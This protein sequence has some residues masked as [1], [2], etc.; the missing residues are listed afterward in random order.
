MNII[1]AGAGRVGYNLAKTLSPYQNVVVIDKNELALNSMQESLDILPLNG[2]VEDPSTYQKLLDREFDLFIAVTDKDEANLI[3]VII[4]SDIIDIERTIIRLEN[5]FFAKSSLMQKF[6]IDEAIFPIE[7]TTNTILNLIYYSKA[8]NV[9][10]FKYT[11][12]KLIS[13][14]LTNLDGAVEIVPQGFII[15]GIERGK[16]FIIPQSNQTLYPNDLIYLFGDDISIIKFCQTY[17]ED[18]NRNENIVIFGAGE[19]GISIA[20]ALLK[21]GKNVKIVDKD[22]KKCKKANSKLSG[23]AIVLNCKYSTSEL[24]EEEGLKYADIVIAATNNDEY[25]IIKCL[26]AKEKGVKKIVAINH[27]LE[28]YQLM[29]SLDI[30]VVRGPKVSAYNTILER[31]HSSSIVAE[32][33]FCGGKGHIY[34]HRI[35]KNSKVVNKEIKIPK[36]KN[37]MAIYLIRDNRILECK[38]S[39]ECKVDD[40]IVA[41]CTIEEDD[42]VERWIH[43]L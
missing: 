24:Y 35:L 9:K 17:G 42:E 23:E 8:N 27:D 14:R 6:G 33:N 26:E 12:K 13:I 43:N 4:A 29:H 7:L 38:N 32:R 5:H 36:W 1:I 22:L 41:F 34:L 3:S 10:S 21:E 40:V 25:N 16:E 37:N 18:I 28:H 11:D 20:N 2:D 39:L 30:V 15:A 19:L 31:I